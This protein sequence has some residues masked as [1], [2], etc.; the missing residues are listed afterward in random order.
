MARLVSQCQY[1]WAITDVCFVECGFLVYPHV[2]SVL[3]CMRLLLIVI[4]L[5]MMLL[6]FCCSVFMSSRGSKSDDRSGKPAQGTPAANTTKDLRAQGMRSCAESIWLK[7][8]LWYN[9]LIQSNSVR[10]L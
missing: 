6:V 2:V 9:M 1:M 3:R 5:N 10:A 8:R 4:G 7:T